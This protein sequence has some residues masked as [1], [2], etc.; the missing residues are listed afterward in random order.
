MFDL[1]R[2]RA[3]RALLEGGLDAA[4]AV[5]DASRLTSDAKSAVWLWV[6]SLQSREEQLER[7]EEYR[8]MLGESYD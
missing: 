7:V 2:S 6:W 8:L 3:S 5:I 1:I 4:E